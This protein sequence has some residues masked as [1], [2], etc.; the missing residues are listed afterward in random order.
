M[1]TF[2]PE[3]SLA[4]VDVIIMGP[5]FAL[6]SAQ[7]LRLFPAEDAPTLLSDH[8]NKPPVDWYYRMP[9]LVGLFD[10]REYRE[11][12]PLEDR[13]PCTVLLQQHGW[14]VQQAMARLFDEIASY[15]VNLEAMPCT[16]CDG[17]GMSMRDDFCFQC[18]G[19]GHPPLKW[20]SKKAK[21]VRHLDP[22]VDR[23]AESFAGT[24]MQVVEA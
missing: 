24:S 8:W 6:Y 5:S 20:L 15:P 10:T 22:G 17:T 9:P 13:L 16:S 2:A 18:N 19:N 3:P 11:L 21:K 7:I 23:L 14:S 12:P 1:A 4:C